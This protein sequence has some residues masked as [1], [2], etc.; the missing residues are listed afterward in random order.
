MGDDGLVGLPG[1]AGPE[2][3]K[4]HRLSGVY[5]HIHVCPLTYIAWSLAFPHCGCE[6]CVEFTYLTVF[7]GRE[8]NQ[9][10]CW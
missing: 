10:S 6:R 5:T 3:E 4:V 2:G 7:A 8:W 9:R 1:D